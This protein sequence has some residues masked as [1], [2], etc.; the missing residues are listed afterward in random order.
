V[1]IATRAEFAAV[2]HGSRLSKNEATRLHLIHNGGLRCAQVCVNP[3][4][5]PSHLMAVSV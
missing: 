4:V 5:R 1:F 2:D 3:G